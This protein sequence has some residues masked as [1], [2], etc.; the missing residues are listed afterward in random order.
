M[1][2]H[3]LHPTMLDGTIMSIKM[4]NYTHT[5]VQVGHQPLHMAALNG[6]IDVAEYLVT[7]CKVP[8]EPVAQVMV[9]SHVYLYSGTSE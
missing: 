3:Q 1:V 9:L 4:Y 6:H 2:Y 7:E 8:I 5:A